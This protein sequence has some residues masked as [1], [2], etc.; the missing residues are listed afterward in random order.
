MKLYDRGQ[1]VHVKVG[2]VLVPMQVVFD[3]GGKV[4]VSRF[5]KASDTERVRRSDIQ[6]PRPKKLVCV[7]TERGTCA[8]QRQSRI[9]TK[10][11]VAQGIITICGLWFQGTT[12]THRAEPTC[13][14]CLKALS[15][16]RGPKKK[17]QSN[18]S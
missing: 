14:G 16:V 5:H 12:G 11:E 6:V 15:V 10:M 17:G 9:P 2:T 3:T 8:T 18:G 13:D 1:L 4:I 7:K